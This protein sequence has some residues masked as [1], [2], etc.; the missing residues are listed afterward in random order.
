M[1]KK[2]KLRFDSSLL[3]L[4]CISFFGLALSFVFV[5]LSGKIPDN[6]EFR[7]PLI[8]LIFGLLCVM[9]T[10]ASIYPDQCLRV[11]DY[12]KVTINRESSR[13]L[14]SP[15]ILG[16]HPVCGN[17]FAHVLEFRGKILCAT[18]TGFSVGAAMALIG[19]GLFFFGPLSFGPAFFVPLTLGVFGV[20]I[21]L[22]HSILPGFKIGFSRFV[23]STFFALGSFLIIASVDVA[24]QNTSIDL[25]FVLLSMLWLV[26]DTALSRWDHRRICAECNLES[27]GKNS[28]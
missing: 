3:F 13:K 22:L 23:V 26:T 6:F 12:E 21:G 2:I 7:K 17:Y 11:L 14:H 20:S 1:S 27:C 4:I 10:F 28:T 5:F 9:G 19:I 25:F 15:T 24:L 16:H 18:C 8:G